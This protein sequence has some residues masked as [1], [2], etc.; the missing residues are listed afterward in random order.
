MPSA[1]DRTHH[2]GRLSEDNTYIFL[3][4]FI[5]I[6]HHN[7]VFLVLSIFTTICWS[8]YWVHADTPSALAAFVQHAVPVGEIRYWGAFLVSP[9]VYHLFTLQQAE[10]KGVLLIRQSDQ[11]QFVV[12]GADTSFDSFSRGPGDSDQI[13]RAAARLLNGETDDPFVARAE[14]S[15]NDVCPLG[16]SLNDLLVPI[17]GFALSCNGTFGI[18]RD[19]QHADSFRVAPEQASPGSIL[20]CPSHFS[21]HGPVNIGFAVVVGPDRCVY[22]PDYRQGGAWRRLATLREWL[23]ANQSASDIHGFLLRADANDRDRSKQRKPSLP[24]H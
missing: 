9:S 18:L 10:R 8:A 3:V 15:A 13:V 4:I 12:V 22:G 6:K 7:N 19:L 14:A 1:F 17:A 2:Q 16:A 21:A 24:Q 23:Q 20:V 5:Y 11:N